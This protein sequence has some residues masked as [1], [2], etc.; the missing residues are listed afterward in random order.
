MHCYSDLLHRYFGVTSYKQNL[1]SSHEQIKKLNPSSKDDLTNDKLKKTW[2]C[3]QQSFVLQEK[4]CL[5]LLHTV[6]EEAKKSCNLYIPSWTVHQIKN[7]AKSYSSQVKKVS[8]KPSLSKK[9]KPTPHF[10][11]KPQKL[12][13]IVSLPL[14][15]FFLYYY[16][17]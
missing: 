14:K 17:Y 6:V 3:T 8:Y 1:S 2:N 10:T 15:L 16:Y 9:G 7:I 12:V 11:K 5:P 13:S 4:N